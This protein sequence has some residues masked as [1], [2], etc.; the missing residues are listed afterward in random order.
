[1]MG[2]MNVH[3]EI[4]FEDNIT[5]LARIQ[6]TTAV[7]PPQAMQ[8]HNLRS[9]FA[10][11]TYLN[12]IGVPAPHVHGYGLAA[13]V[14]GVGV[15]YILQDQLKG[16]PPKWQ[17][18]GSDE[19]HQVL[20]QLANIFVALDHHSFRRTGSIQLQESVGTFADRVTFESNHPQQLSLLGPFTS[21]SEHLYHTITCYLH[22]IESSQWAVND[23]VSSYLIYRSLLDIYSRIIPFD[24]MNSDIFCLRHQDDKGDHIL[25]NGKLDIVGI[26]D[27]EWSKVVGRSFAFAAPI[28]LLPLAF[29]EGDNELS[30]DEEDLAEIFES[31]GRPDMA[32]CVRNGRVFHRISFILDSGDRPEACKPHLRGLYQLLGDGTWEWE[33]WRLDALQRYQSDSVLKRLLVEEVVI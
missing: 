31:L 9:E 2:G 23:S 15:N 18:L 26:I 4:L 14:N 11:L 30:K 19:R 10:T 3:L 25:I 22:L 13:D 21:L 24:S 29:D 33:T 32:L 16:S 20:A 6:R 17:D 8:D 5:W 7:T 27:W 28:M 12:R 1:M